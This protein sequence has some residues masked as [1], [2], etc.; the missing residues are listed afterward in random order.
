MTRFTAHQLAAELPNA[1]PPRLSPAACARQPLVTWPSSSVGAPAGAGAGA[2]RDALAGDEMQP[3]AR[4]MRAFWREVARMDEE[5]PGAID[6][7]ASWPLVPVLGGELVRVGHRAAVVAPPAGAVGAPSLRRARARADD[8][9]LGLTSPQFPAHPLSDDDDDA[10]DDD[11]DDDDARRPGTFASL[12]IAD[13]AR[14]R[15]ARLGPGGASAAAPQPLLEQWDW[16]AP[17]LR[18]IGAPTLDVAAAGEAAARAVDAA[19]PA[20]PTAALRTAADVVAFKAQQIKSCLGG[21]RPSFASVTDAQRE[22]L[23]QLFASQHASSGFAAS[24]EGLETMRSLPMFTAANGEKVDV[25]SGEYVT[26]PPGVAFAETLSR[27]GGVLEHRASSRDLYAALGVPELSDADVLARFVAPSLRDMAPEARRDALAYVRKH[28][29]RLRDDD[30]LCRALGAAKFV[31]V[32]RDDGGEG[33][34]DGG[35]DDDGVELKSPGELYDPE[36]ELLAAV[37]RGQSG[38]FPSRKWSTRAWLPMLRDVGLRSAVDATLFQLCATRVAARAISLGIAHPRSRHGDGDGELGPG[39]R[40]RFV[41][42][43]PPPPPPPELAAAVDPPSSADAPSP[44]VTTIDDDEELEDA[45]ASSEREAGLVIAAGAML[46]S[47]LSKHA[48]DLYNAPNGCEVRS[49]HWSPYDRVG[50]V[51]A[52]S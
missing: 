49:I 32:L 24:G 12:L 33:D 43:P 45:R 15:R 8:A 4:W 23:F 40:K 9:A 21:G 13:A 25:A 16:L 52:V 44:L 48:A 41:P 11:A 3:S 5:N 10:D 31:D 29:H 14:E 26:C 18:D 2:G 27:F 17:L 22:R 51:N 7:F 30:P 46:A 42:P 47:H 1:L 6:A 19:R 34:D 35:D 36:V 38:C 37:F 50:V 20:A 28:W 39:R